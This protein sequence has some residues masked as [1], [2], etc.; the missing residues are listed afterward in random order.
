MALEPVRYPISIERGGTGKAERSKAFTNLGPPSP[1]TDDV[2]V[3][4]GGDWVSSSRLTDAEADIVALSGVVAALELDDLADVD[5][6]G[7]APGDV[8]TYDG[9][10]WV[11]DTSP[12]GSSPAARI[13][14]GI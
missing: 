10:D 13:I 11:P 8:L 14:G 1:A 9:A 4:D 3:W 12:G 6:T 2:I 5:T 7:V